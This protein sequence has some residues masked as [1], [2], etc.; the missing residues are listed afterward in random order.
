MVTNYNFEENSGKDDSKIGEEMNGR[1]LDDGVARD[2]KNAKG[3]L[4]IIEAEIY[5]KN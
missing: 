4:S 1:K 3:S 2:D 5:S